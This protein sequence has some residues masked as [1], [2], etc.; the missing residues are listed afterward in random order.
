MAIYFIA[1]GDSSKNR[2]KT[3]DR[4]HTV[5]ELLPEVPPTVG[6]RLIDAFPSGDGV[7]AWGGSAPRHRSVL[8]LPQGTYV[9]DIANSDVKQVFRFAFAFEAPD[10]R[11]QD[12]FDWDDHVAPEERRPYPIVYFLQGPQP[13]S[14]V[15]SQWFRR[16]FD[17]GHANWLPGQRLFSDREVVDA[18]ERTSTS[19]VEEFLGLASAEPRYTAPGGSG[20]V[21]ETRRR[22]YWALAADPTRYRIDEAVRELREDSWTTKG[23]DIREGD[24]VVVWRTS[25]G[26]GPRGVVALGE[27]TGP[28]DERSDANNPYW[29]TPDRTVSPRVPVRYVVPPGL[30]LF[31]GDDGSGPVRALSVSRARGGTVFNVS[32]G[33][34]RALISSV[35]GFEPFLRGAQDDAAEDEILASDLSPTEKD[36]L[37]RA[38]RGQGAFRARV[39]SIESGCRLTGTTDPSLLVA[40]HIK[41]W[42]D[43]TDAERLDGENGLLLAPHVDR[44]FDLGRISFEDGGGVIVAGPAAR[45]EVERWSLDPAADV[46][47]FTARQRYYLSYHREYVLSE[48]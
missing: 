26:R 45:D 30:P 23:R 27:V 1:A 34:W 40:S 44:L 14:R 48:E 36:Q 18:M 33:Q 47:P 20:R 31:L 19:T 29:T 7:Y 13:T 38:R 4:A 39:M 8:G 24:R 16:A 41:P 2:E 25:G 35:G 32:E 11:I 28:V 9:V 21:A 6:R 37:V 12:H 10:S 46:G 15:Q 22:Q 43:S 17:F 3:L 42:R 5:D